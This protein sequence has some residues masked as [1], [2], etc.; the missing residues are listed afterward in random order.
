VEELRPGLW[1]WTAVHPT[2]HEHV[3]GSYAWDAGSTLVL[4]D[5]LSP[6][7]LVDELAD[8]KEV[9]TVLTCDWHD[10]N[11]PE[12]VERLGA[13]VHAPAGGDGELE[14]RH[15]EPDDALPAGLAA[16]PATH[17]GE[18]A[19]WI[20]EAGALVVGD[21]LITTDGVLAIPERWL[22]K[23]D[24]VA[25]VR[26]RLAPLLELPVE[27][28]LTTHGEPVREN[29]AEALRRALLQSSS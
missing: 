14:A 26:K 25:D 22:P 6:P 23:G 5:P 9:A 2:W 11:A 28:V 16:Y 8:G 10:R 18:A 3:V 12:L 29:G 7:S 19:L 24:S 21:A 20:A 17:P 27:L 4:L 15:F 1:Y 13:A